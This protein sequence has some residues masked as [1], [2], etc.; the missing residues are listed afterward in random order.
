[1]TWKLKKGLDDIE[2]F[3]SLG[4]LQQL[5]NTKEAD[6]NDT[7]SYDNRTWIPIHTVEN[8][9]GFFNEI[10][11]RAEHGELKPALAVSEPP[12][13]DEDEEF[14][15]P[16]KVIRNVGELLKDFE[17]SEGFSGKTPTPSP[18]Y[19][20]RGSNTKPI[21]LDSD[22]EDHS[23][24]IEEVVKVHDPNHIAPEPVIPDTPEP[25]PPAPEPEHTGSLER[26]LMLILLAIFVSTSI[27]A[28]LVWMDI[29]IPFL[30]DR[31]TEQPQNRPT[32]STPTDR[33]S[34]PNK[35]Q[36]VPTDRVAPEPS[37]H[38]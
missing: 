6:D 11:K 25:L 4:Q 27:F 29:E 26:R 3:Y 23:S 32:I 14:D 1:M 19:R 24:V 13:P 20:T 38:P 36:D 31:M 17:K 21:Y 16:T 37:E 9:A 28:A 30:T 35:E 33:S 10:W 12:P 22:T 2:V 5:L 34:V 7:I 15:A 18:T 8:L